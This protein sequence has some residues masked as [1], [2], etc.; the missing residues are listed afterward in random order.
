MS[1]S[2]AES[3]ALRARRE[4]DP[5]EAIQL[6]VKSIQQLCKEVKSLQSEVQSLKRKVR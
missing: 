1:L 6:L 4:T 3:Y 5:D 2:Y